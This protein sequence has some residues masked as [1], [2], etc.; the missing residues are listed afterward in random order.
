M[1]R[2]VVWGGAVRCGVGLVEGDENHIENFK[3][4]IVARKNTKKN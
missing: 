1:R 3:K 2:G 4:N